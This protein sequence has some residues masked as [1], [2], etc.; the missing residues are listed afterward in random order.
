MVES[1][2]NR[3]SAA[4]AAAAP[5]GPA[6]AILIPVKRLEDAK[7]RLHPALGPD[8]RRRLAL[9]MLDDVLAAA[10][11]WPLRL[12]CTADAEVASLGEPAGWSIVDD[13]GPDLNAAVAAGTA[14]ALAGGAAALLVLP[15][16]VPLV[17]PAEL[18][19]IF[20]AG[21]DVVVAP[22]DDGGTAALLRRPP[23]AI[24]PAFGPGSAGRHLAAAAASG[25]RAE[26]VRLPGLRLDVDDLEDL[27]RLAAAPGTARSIQ[28]ARE[29]VAAVPAADP[30]AGR[31]RP[32]AG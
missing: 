6:D 26:E 2:G 24:D 4:P 3:G 5:R 19:A 11:S 15:F 28:V 12:I 17:V 18:A 22:S 13:P 31:R 8:A 1:I 14:A 9:A 16:D 20:G 7:L 27:R 30:A 21:A 32:A 23:G 29:L 25:L 10:A